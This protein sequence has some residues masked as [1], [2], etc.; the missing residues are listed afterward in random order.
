MSKRGLY[1][2]KI[3]DEHIQQLYQWAKRLGIPM[4]RLVNRLLAHGLTRL[5]HGVENVSEPV[6]H[7]YARKTPRTK[8]GARSGTHKPTKEGE[9]NEHQEQT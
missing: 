2:P 1:Q 9:R 8:R 7:D 3:A 6:G 4:T 5:E